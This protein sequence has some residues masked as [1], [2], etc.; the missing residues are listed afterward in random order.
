MILTGIFVAF[1]IVGVILFAGFQ[2]SNQAVIGNVVI[3]GTLDKNL[4]SEFLNE[5]R[6]K[7]DSF[8]NVSYV[9]IN[10][11]TFDQQLAEAL[12]SGKG[13]DVFL[14]PQHSILRHEDK[15][16]TVPYDSYSLRDFKN[17]FIEEGE[18]YLN[19]EGVIAFPFVIDPLV[20]YWNRDIFSNV[21]VAIPP[22]TW[23]EFF[24][25]SHKIT[26][27][28]DNLNIFRSAVSFGEFKNV[29]HAKEIIS[30]LII[31]AGDPITQRSGNRINVSL[32]S[33][34]TEEAIDF[35]TQFS[36]PVKSVYTWNR[37]L[38]SSEKYFISGDLALYFGFA[39][40]LE[41]LQK[42]N[43][44]LNFDVTNVPQTT[45]GSGVT[46]G[47]MYSLAITKSS[48]NMA[49]AFNVVKIMTDDESLTSLSN[50]S[51][52][53]PVSRNLLSKETNNPYLE[54]FYNSALLSKAWLDPNNSETNLIFSEMVESII[55]GRNTIKNAIQNASA[56]I[57]EL[58]N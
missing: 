2:G 53:P 47:S 8:K 57:N 39:S 55:S 37:S 31:Q 14:L 13:P 30:M 38:P 29:A 6:N 3:W 7:N 26:K 15:I 12:S 43:P 22:K 58:A 24:S 11:N 54:I 32:D 27:K 48:Q 51:N 40:E 52:L 34:S 21:G 28:D 5:L 50:L 56:E 1:I 16:I 33:K 41:N 44:N 10:E 25:L 45:S 23:E 49:S 18:L 36:N 42:K 46:F 35:F 17:K 9:Q 20:M 19:N 4:M